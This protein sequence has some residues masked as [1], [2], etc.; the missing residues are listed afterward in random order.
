MPKETRFVSPEQ[1]HRNAHFDSWISDLVGLD[2][3]EVQLPAEHQEHSR[4]FKNPARRMAIH[5]NDTLYLPTVNRSSYSNIAVFDDGVYFTTHLAIASPDTIKIGIQGL[6][7]PKNLLEAETSTSS[8]LELLIKLQSA[9]HI[10]EAFHFEQFWLNE[11]L[12]GSPWGRAL[13][14]SFL[15][16]LQPPVELL[17]DWQRQLLP[18]VAPT[19]HDRGAAS[20]FISLFASKELRSSMPRL[21]QYSNSVL[22]TGSQIAEEQLETW[23]QTVMVEWVDLLLNE[24]GTAPGGTTEEI[25]IAA[26]WLKETVESVREDEKSKTAA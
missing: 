6:R 16:E 12:D 7:Q 5:F 23:C 9:P 4:F 11:I 25:L 17:T 15:Y 14:A 18:E 2:F 1:I 10:L 20:L 26:T 22:T 8:L 13:F 3:S 19:A 24:S 21:A